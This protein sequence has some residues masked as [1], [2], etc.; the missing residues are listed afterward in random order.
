MEMTNTRKSSPGFAKEFLNKI[1]VGYALDLWFKDPVN[2]AKLVFKDA[3]WWCQDAIVEPA[4]GSLRKGI[5]FECHEVFYSGHMGI[6][7]TLKQDDTN[8][9][10]PKLR[11]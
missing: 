5:L 10:W 4:V 8:F 3:I 2:F 6:M 7:K 11:E 9:W 1:I